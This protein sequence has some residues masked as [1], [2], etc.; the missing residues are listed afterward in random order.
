MCHARCHCALE[1]QS[2]VMAVYFCVLPVPASASG[3]V[4]CA[5][6]SRL[7]SH[8]CFK[9]QLGFRRDSEHSKALARE[10]VGAGGHHA[11]Y[12]G[13][14]AGA[15]GSGGLYTRY[16]GICGRLARD[17]TTATG[18][19]AFP[20]AEPEPTR[21]PAAMPFDSSTGVCR[22]FLL[23]F[24][25]GAGAC[26]NCILH[27]HGLVSSLFLSIFYMPYMPHLAPGATSSSYIPSQLLATSY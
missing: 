9:P 18:R 5:G 16:E 14:G 21:D 23:F 19:S 1:T 8:G 10:G 13:A 17:I 27:G 2:V 4:T 26:L 7:C 22:F 20:T 6:R 15:V 12:P 24:W 11:V 3:G 25:A